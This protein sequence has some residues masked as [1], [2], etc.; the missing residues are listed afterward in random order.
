M[1]RKAFDTFRDKQYEIIAGINQTKGKD[2]AGN[3]D[4][5]A[6]FK[7]IAKD[8]DMD[9]LKVWGVYASKHWSAV[10][11]FIREGKVASEPIEGRLHDVILYCFLLLGLIEERKALVSDRVN[12]QISQHYRTDKLYAGTK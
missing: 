9:P 7:V 1:D 2:Y 12:E 3:T 4:A 5:L 10:M 8:L 11:T 6:N